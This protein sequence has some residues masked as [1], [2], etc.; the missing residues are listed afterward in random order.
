MTGRKALYISRLMSARIEGLPP[1]ENEDLL[2]ELFEISEDPRIIF[3]HKWKL[4]DLVM[5][6]NYASIH[7]R[8]D[9]P[10]DEP[11]LMRRLTLAGYGPLN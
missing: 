10:R 4:G 5:W 11:R 7:R 3:E 6:D 8:N 2:N 1:D 9:F